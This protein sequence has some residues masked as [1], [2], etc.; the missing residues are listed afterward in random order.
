MKKAYIIH[1]WGGDS[2]SDWIPWLK[3]DLESK[4]FEVFTPDMPD[5]DEP[6]I[7]RWV[8][9]LREIL[10]NPDE[11]C[12][13]IGH[14]IGCQTIMRYLESLD[15]KVLDKIILIAPWFN[16]KGLEDE[17]WS[18]VDSWINTPI[19]FEK[20]KSSTKEIIALFSSNDPFVPIEDEK[21]FKERLNSK[22]I[23]VNN[24]GHFIEDDGIVEI[25]EI[26]EFLK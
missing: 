25:P 9:K 8:A 20:V 17:E 22:N 15:G 21:L 7:E 12:V 26:L 18:I 11:D 14:S 1:G 16:L 4:K 2:K 24:K 19:N 5:T 13:L 3:K 23:I 6:V 10:V